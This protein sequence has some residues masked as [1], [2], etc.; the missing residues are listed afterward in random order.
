[1]YCRMREKVLYLL[2]KGREIENI[3]DEFTYG[4]KSRAGGH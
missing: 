1:M 4:R 3:K 2:S